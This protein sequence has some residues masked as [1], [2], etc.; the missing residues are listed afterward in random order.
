MI[1]KSSLGCGDYEMVEPKILREV[2]KATSAKI[3]R[4]FRT[5]DFI[6]FRAVVSRIL[7]EAVQKAQESWLSDHLVVQEQ[8]TPMCK[9]EHVALTQ[10]EAG[11]V[12]QANTE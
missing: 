7:W 4:N 10:Q 11:L 12:E 3:I 9:T 8:S 5:A 6:F 2:R 1:A